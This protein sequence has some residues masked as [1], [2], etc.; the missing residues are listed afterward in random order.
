MFVWCFYSCNSEE[1]EP[2]DLGFDFYPIAQSERIYAVSE[3]LFDL[4]GST[5]IE[6]Q[7]REYISDSIVSTDGLKN[8]IIKRDTRIDESS[9]WENDSF[10]TIRKNER[11]VIVTE[12]NVSFAKLSFPIFINK[13]W[14]GNAYNTQSASNYQFVSN[15]PQQVT[16]G[17]I[18]T[19]TIR[20]IIADNP[21]NLVGQD[22]RYEV[23]A[24]GIG[25]I[26]KN[27][28]TLNFCTAN[29]EGAEAIESGMILNQ[30]LIEYVEK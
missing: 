15:E 23:Y 4:R 14:N 26:E 2:I 1:A 10:W 27:Y 21:V 28:I 9:D 25:L 29:C 18:T 22:E 20:V 5:T 7:L 13:L 12:D 3:T 19:E 24:K 30:V 17:D 8:Y 11:N 6:Y 16:I